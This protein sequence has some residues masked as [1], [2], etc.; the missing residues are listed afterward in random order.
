MQQD[1]RVLIGEVVRGEGAILVDQ[2]G[3]RFVNEMDTRD[4]VS[5]AITALPEKSAYLI[6]DQGVRDRATA[7]EFYDQK[8]YVT[9]GKT[10]EELAEKID[11]PKETLAKTVDGWNT[12]VAE[13]KDAQFNRATAME[14]DLSSPNYYAIKIAPG[15]HYTMGGVKINTN[16]EV[17]DKE[18]QPIR[19]LYAAGEV[20]GG[21][22]GNN[23]IGGNSVAE[24]IIFGRQ[25]GIQAAR[26]ASENE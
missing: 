25:A 17:L 21:L 15:I 7:I 4:K 24:I 8:G 9:T 5:A 14:H 26:F 20:T 11:L 1:E 13:K 2:E 18:N 22:H 16:T 19:G 10:M 3:K 23:R 12:D 6:F